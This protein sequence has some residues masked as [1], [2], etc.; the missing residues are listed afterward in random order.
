MGRA[1]IAVATSMAATCVRIDGTLK[2]DV[3]A[4]VLADDGSGAERGYCC[5]DLGGGGGV[6]IGP[7]V[8]EGLDLSGFE[9]TAGVGFGSPTS[10]RG[11]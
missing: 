6:F 9:P 1:S 11:P 7:A 8:V 3:W 5:W 4:L 10:D 2:A